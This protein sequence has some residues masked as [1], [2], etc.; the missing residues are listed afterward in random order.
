MGLAGWRDFHRVMVQAARGQVHV[1]G[2]GGGRSGGREGSGG[3][4][5]TEAA[6]RGW[7]WLSRA[8]PMAGPCFL[9]SQGD[10]RWPPAAPGRTASQPW[11]GQEERS[12]GQAQSG[13][14]TP[15]QT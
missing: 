2:P 3:A 15:Q 7:A 5:G 1:H 8:R 9:P 12:Q 10:S 11:G 13:G 14:M 4:W 6:L